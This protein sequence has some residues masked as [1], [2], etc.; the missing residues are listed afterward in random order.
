M[1][2][3]KRVF[4]GLLTIVALAALGFI[5]WAGNP[6]KASPE[7]LSALESDSQVTVSLEDGYISFQPAG[8]VPETA[9][10]FYPGARVDYRA[11]A[12]PLRQ[13]AAQGYQVILLQVKLNHAIFD[14]D[15]AE[16][17]FGI[18]PHIKNWVVGG[19]SLGG[20]VAASFA[21]SHDVK[22]L[23]LW[24]SY[25]IDDLLKNKNLS[26]IS[27]YGTLDITEMNIYDDKQTLLPSNTEYIII[28]G[29]NH[30]QFGDYGFQP[31]DNEATISRAEQQRQVVDATVKFLEMLD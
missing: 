19:H 16:K 2:F 28:Q 17:V 23:V 8:T 11:Y 25:P 6:L 5:A 15:A 4:L 29:G 10:A 31:G 14:A 20:V 9:L 22:G 26:V 18:Y 3:M 24:A 13:I 21:A 12:V 7:A 30:A 1:K 27:I